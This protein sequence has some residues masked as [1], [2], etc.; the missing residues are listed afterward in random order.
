MSTHAS[1][2]DIGNKL[3]TSNY[4][5]DDNNGDK[6]F[7]TAARDDDYDGERTSDIDDSANLSGL[8]ESEDELQTSFQK[9]TMSAKNCRTGGPS[10]PDYSR[11][12]KKEASLEM[13]NYNKVRKAYT[14]KLCNNR[15]KANK[16]TVTANVQCSGVTVPCLRSSLKSKA[17]A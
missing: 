11:M 13:A 15:V 5:D 8:D 14:D 12:T 16:S 9:N 3:P 1:S 6:S 7:N 17:I 10:P 4:E 2:N